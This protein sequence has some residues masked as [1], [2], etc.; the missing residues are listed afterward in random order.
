MGAKTSGVRIAQKLLSVRLLSV[1]CLFSNPFRS[2]HCRLT[3]RGND[4][5]H[6]IGHQFCAAFPHMGRPSATESRF[7]VPRRWQDAVPTPA[8]P[9]T[10]HHATVRTVDR[11]RRRPPRRT[12]VAAVQHGVFDVDMRH[13]SQPR[14]ATGRRVASSTWTKLADHASA[15][16]TVSRFQRSLTASSRIADDLLLILSGGVK[17]LAS[18]ASANRSA[19]ADLAVIIRI[20]R[21]IRRWNELRTIRARRYPLFGKS[22]QVIN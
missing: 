16:L 7:A 18:F 6:H 19:G 10:Q 22:A 15:N 14:P 17:L 8:C 4:S 1:N 2:P 9:D 20:R 13:I 21:R 3:I 5:L 11:P 12:Y